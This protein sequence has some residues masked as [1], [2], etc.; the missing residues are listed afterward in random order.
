MEKQQ[1]EL[2]LNEQRAYFN[3]GKT[4][5]VGT[6]IKA[7]KKLRDVIVRKE[8]EIANALYHL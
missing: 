8:R 2:I 6:R 3:D 1:I 4:L 7:L 5:D